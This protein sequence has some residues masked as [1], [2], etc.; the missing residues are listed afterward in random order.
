MG[1]DRFVA[2]DFF[3]IRIRA[4][5]VYI[6]PVPAYPKKQII[7]RQDGHTEFCRILAY[8]NVRIYIFI[9]IAALH[10]Q[11]FSFSVTRSVLSYKTHHARDATVTHV[12]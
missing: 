2:V 1:I 5:D 10:V 7:S 12:G 8:A 9:K 11:G 3:F 4:R 6:G